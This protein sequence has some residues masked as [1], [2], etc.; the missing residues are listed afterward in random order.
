MIDPVLLSPTFRAN[1]MYCEFGFYYLVSTRNVSVVLK[2]QN[3]QTGGVE[4]LDIEQQFF[5]DYQFLNYF[6][7]AMPTVK[8]SIDYRLMIIGLF[9]FEINNNALRH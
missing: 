5:Q 8:R 9:T 1:G 7:Y 4:I 2:L 3:V 6:S